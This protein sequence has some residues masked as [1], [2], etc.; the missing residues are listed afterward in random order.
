[1]LA[2][3]RLLPRCSF[4]SDI[5]FDCS[6][7]S[8]PRKK[9]YLLLEGCIRIL[10]ISL[11]CSL[12]AHRLISKAFPLQQASGFPQHNIVISFMTPAARRGSYLLKSI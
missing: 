11:S 1:M 8:D 5:A 4:A 12:A 7:A 3:F 10:G 6:G 2:T 9:T